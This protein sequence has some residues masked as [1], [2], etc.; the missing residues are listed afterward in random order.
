M[1]SLSTAR[2]PA[3]PH[4]HARLPNQRHSA[5]RGK[6][7]CW[8]KN[9]CTRHAMKTTKRLQ[10]DKALIIN[11]I[12]S[13]PCPH[14]QTPHTQH[15]HTRYSSTLYGAGGH[16]KFSQHNHFMCR[17]CPM[18]AAA[19]VRLLCCVSLSPG[20]GP[21]QGG[22]FTELLQAELLKAIAP[23]THGKRSLLY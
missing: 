13:N 19:Y 15:T 7:Y 16:H 22:R 4:S 8:Y 10:R 18:Q 21:W 9:T 14:P 2:P 1:P 5:D 17:A 23:C 3:H 12:S 11:L 6:E 20:V